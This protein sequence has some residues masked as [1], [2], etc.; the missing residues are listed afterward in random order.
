VSD[1]HVGMILSAASFAAHKH[2]DQRRKGADAAPYINHPLAVANILWHEGGVRDGAVIAAA[3][4]HDTIEDTETSYDELVVQF[5][6]VVA[7]YVQEVTDDKRLPKD[8]RKQLQVEHAPGL[9]AGAKL[10]KLGD[11]IANLRDIG[12]CP[13]ADWTLERRREYFEWAK[14]VVDAIGA[15]PERG[16]LDAFAKAYAGKP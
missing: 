3:L 11:K 16:L 6:T 9:S 13:P 4:L 12:T 5:G 15:M 14:R 10:V 2:R 7:E 8:V 1:E